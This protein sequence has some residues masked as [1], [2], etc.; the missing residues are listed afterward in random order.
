MGDPHP[1]PPPS[2]NFAMARKRGWMGVHPLDEKSARTILTW[3]YAP[4]Y[5]FYNLTPAE[6]EVEETL[7]YLLDPANTFYGLFDA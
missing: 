2:L 6:A 5:D 3:Q 7:R 4:P 1:H